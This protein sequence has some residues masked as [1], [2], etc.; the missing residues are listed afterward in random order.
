MNGT[1]RV[2][3]DDDELTVPEGGTISVAIG[4]RHRLQNP[5]HIPLVVIEVQ[6]GSY[7]GEDDIERYADE[8]GRS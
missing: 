1:A 6:L 5:G 2:T 8:Y 4:A 7:L 3:L